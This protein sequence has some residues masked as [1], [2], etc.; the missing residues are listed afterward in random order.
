VDEAHIRPTRMWELLSQDNG[1]SHPEQQHLTA[2]HECR[3]FVLEF[4]HLTSELTRRDLQNLLTMSP[5][6]KTAGNEQ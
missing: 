6:R 5:A 4:I 1:L 3:A 2:C